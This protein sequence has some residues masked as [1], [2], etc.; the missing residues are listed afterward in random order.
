M[1]DEEKPDNVE[2]FPGTP[3]EM[4]AVAMPPIV[5]PWDTA[6]AELAERLVPDID[7]PMDPGAKNAR[8]QAAVVLAPELKTGMQAML[9]WAGV[10]LYLRQ[11]QSALQQLVL[12]A[13][14]HG[15]T[16]GRHN[17]KALVF[18]DRLQVLAD[19]MQTGPKSHDAAAAWWEERAAQLRELAELPRIVAMVEREMG[20]T[21]PEAADHSN[22]EKI[23]GMLCG[24]LGIVTQQKEMLGQLREQNQ[25]LEAALKRNVRR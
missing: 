5:L 6:A 4:H 11:V 2:P 3:S 16:R 23:E 13:E 24:L 1:I 14:V 21:P 15:P 12:R 10:S 25:R 7:N 17:A 20:G 18:A 9:A 22:A 19:L 8:A